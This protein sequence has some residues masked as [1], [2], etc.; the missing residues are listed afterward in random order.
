M[1]RMLAATAALVLISVSGPGVSDA[2]ADLCRL[3]CETVT[4]GCKATFG[5]IDEDYC[6]DWRDGCVT[7]CQVKH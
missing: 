1:R 3:Y 5:K 4:A 6:E 7:G 2:E